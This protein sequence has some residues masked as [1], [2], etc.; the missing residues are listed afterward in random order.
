MFKV[1][2]INIGSRQKGRIQAA[3]VINCNIDKNE[4][5]NAIDKAFSKEFRAKAENA[6][7][8]YGTGE[9]SKLIVDITKKFLENGKIDLRKSF[10]NIEVR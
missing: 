9:S 6:K 5:V 2:T 3:N 4:I 8:P 7:N 10:Y 1:P